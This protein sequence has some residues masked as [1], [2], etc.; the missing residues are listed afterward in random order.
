MEQQKMKI[1]R[2]SNIWLELVRFVIIGGYATILDMAVEG[3]VTS[4]LAGKTSGAGPVGAFFWMFLFSV[5][6]EFGLGFPERRQR[7]GENG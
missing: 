1:D 4:A 2:D 3:W 5:V 6:L 7:G